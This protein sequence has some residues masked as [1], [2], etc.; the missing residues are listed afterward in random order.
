MS[1]PLTTWPCVALAALVLHGAFAWHHRDLATAW[2]GVPTAP[3]AALASLVTLG[4]AQLFYRGATFG[5]QNMGDQGGR[6]T[7][8]VDYDYDRLGVWFDLLD[9]LDPTANYVPTL[10]AFYFSQTP[11]KEDLRSI[12]GYLSRIG[13]RDPARNW[14]WLAHAVYLARHRLGDLS[15]ALEVAQQLAGLAGSEAPL[16]VKQMPAFVLAA[17]GEREAADDLLQ[18]ILSTDPNL[19]VDEIAFMQRF[20]AEH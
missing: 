9:G 19:S 3:P 4:D 10:A 11:A 2:A 20:I 14:R 15:L 8:L 13:S 18:T 5:L 1:A 7:P 6:V 12:V 17:V 16:W